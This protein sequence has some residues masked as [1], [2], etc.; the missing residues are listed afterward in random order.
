MHTSA[1]AALPAACPLAAIQS[2]APS[3]QP[4]H[5]PAPLAMLRCRPSGKRRAGLWI[6]LLV[7]YQCNMP[8]RSRYGCAGGSNDTA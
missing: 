3:D 2:C 4:M 8:T 1:A 5:T 7:S 6:V